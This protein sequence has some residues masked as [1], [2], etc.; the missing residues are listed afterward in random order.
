MSELPPT[1]EVIDVVKHTVI[2]SVA[3]AFWA[4]VIGGGLAW[5]VAQALGREWRGIAP[6]V[7][8][9]SLA[10]ALAVG[11]ESRRVFPWVPDGKP[12]HWAWPAIG[13]ALAVELV[14][15]TPGVAVGVGNLLRG[16]A[17]GVIAGF[18]VPPAEQADMRWLVPAFG[19]AVA[20]Q[21]ATVDAV[22]RRN[23]GGSVALAVAVACGGAAA[24][25]IHAEQAGFTDTATFLHV[26]LGVMAVLAWV[27]RADAGAAAAVAT[28][29]LAVVLLLGRF[30][31]D[32]E[33]S[34]LIFALVGFAPAL[35]GLFL[36]PGLDRWSGRV[37]G[38]VFRMAVVAVPVGFAV[39]RATV[40][41][42]LVFGEKW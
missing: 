25:L 36:L 10:A 34:H 27:A 13:L 19:F 42:P 8:V 37:T 16:T 31:R 2:P 5:G 21:W 15:R 9:V 4:A 35:M 22:G 40:D 18:V 33:V 32:S 3:A 23:P 38:A 39:Y 14:A 41:A 28:V 7:A 26:G 17:A 29:P 1:A 11:N 12:W 30:L 24:V 20:A 6:W